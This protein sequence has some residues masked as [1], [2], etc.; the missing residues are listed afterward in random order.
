MFHSTK[1][2]SAGM[3]LFTCTK[4]KQQFFYGYICCTLFSLHFRSLLIIYMWEKKAKCSLFFLFFFN[5]SN[6][7]V[8]QIDWNCCWFQDLDGRAYSLSQNDG[9][10]R[11]S[12]MVVRILWQKLFPL[13]C[14]RE[15]VVTFVSEE[16]MCAFHG[17]A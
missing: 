14:V 9:Y 8:E 7:W 4:C 3:Q 5:R 16:M 2:P 12:F 6:C 10:V 1:T 11:D 13:S 17:V 15:A